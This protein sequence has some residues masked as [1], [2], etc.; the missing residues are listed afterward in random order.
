MRTLEREEGGEEREE[1]RRS[2]GREARVV[3]E[4][5]A[6]KAA[7][8]KKKKV[9]MVVRKNGKGCGV[10]SGIVGKV[11]HPSDGD[12]ASART[13]R[14]MNREDFG[15]TLLTMPGDDK[16]A[17]LKWLKEWEMEQKERKS[18][19]RKIFSGTWNVQPGRCCPA[20]FSLVW[21]TILG[22]QVYRTSFFKRV[23]GDA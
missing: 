3:V 17:V 10:G 23:C 12:V 4:R 1:S 9:Q 11:G 7:V 13:G 5:S 22:V 6:S 18:E 15:A 8:K 19:G 20:R 2:L 21:V 14:M 16:V